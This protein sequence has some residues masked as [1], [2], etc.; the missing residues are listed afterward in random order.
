MKIF[1]ESCYSQAYMMDPRQGA[2]FHWK[3]WRNVSKGNN[4]KHRFDLSF[5]S[6]DG[7]LVFCG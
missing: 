5:L 7:K 4:S 6:F 1:G 2:N 3:D